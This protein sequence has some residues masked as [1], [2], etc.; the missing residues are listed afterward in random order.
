MMKPRMHKGRTG[1][2]CYRPGAIWSIGFGET[3]AE[4]YGDWLIWKHMDEQRC[5]G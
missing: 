1:W 5:R 4:A 3:M 2:L